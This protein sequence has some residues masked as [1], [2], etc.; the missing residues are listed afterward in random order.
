MIGN[1]YSICIA[2]FVDCELYRLS[3]HHSSDSFTVLV[4]ALNCCYVAQ[5]NCAPLNV[6]N[7]RIAEF[8]LVLK[9]INCTYQEALIAFFQAAAREI[10]IFRPYSIDDLLDTDAELRQLLLVDTNL[11]L[12][13]EAATHLDGGSTFRG[14][15]IRLDAVFGQSAQ[16]F[17]PNF[18]RFISLCCVLLV[19]QAE[20]DDRFGRWIETQ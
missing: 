19:Q 13:F 1:L 20:A 4:A 2:F 7:D 15:N 16:G 12:V 14:F 18:A 11:N 3:P 6:G 10:D 9:L 5:I 17:Q 8:V